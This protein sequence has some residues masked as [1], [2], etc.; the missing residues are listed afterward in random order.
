[1]AVGAAAALGRAALGRAATRNGRLWKLAVILAGG[2][3]TVLMPVLVL[4]AFR[5]VTA[6]VLQHVA[7]APP[8]FLAID[9]YRAAEQCPFARGGDAGNALGTAFLV[10]SA[11]VMTSDGGHQFG[12]YRNPVGDPSHVPADM[13]PAD[14]SEL[15]P[16]GG[17]HDELRLPTSRAVQP[18]DWTSVAPLSGEYGVGFL[19][20]TRSDW[21]NWARDVPAS[22]SRPL[23]PYQPYDAFMVMACHLRAVEHHAGVDAWGAM[24]LWA[25]TQVLSADVNRALSSGLDVRQTIDNIVSDLKQLVSAGVSLGARFANAVASFMGPAAMGTDELAMGQVPPS[26]A[27]LQ[28]IPPNYLVLIRKWAAAYGIDWTV[29]AGLLMVEDSFGQG[30]GRS[31]AGALGPAQFLPS[32]F[33]QYGVDDGSDGKTDAPDIWN[34][35]DAIASAAN[36]LKALGAG[37]TSTLRSA[38]CRYNT[39]GPGSSAYQPCMDGTQL[40]FDYAD[41][42][43][44]YARQYR[45]ALTAVTTGLVTGGS[46]PAAI[47][48]AIDFAMKQLGKPYLYGGTGPDSWDCSGLVQ[49]AYAAAGIQL[50]RTSQ[51]QWNRGPRVGLPHQPGDLVFFV[52]ADGTSTAPGHVGL[53]IDSNHMIVAPSTGLNV[54]IQPI[55]SQ[56]YVGATRPSAPSTTQV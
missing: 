35:A 45:G 7:V 13:R 44:S 34:P 53:A 14:P 17:V 55:Y 21:L 3:V 24:A 25:A 38:L 36:Y 18:Q 11:W 16:G 43:M 28:S 4:M 50:P 6:H 47:Q 54:Q 42:V 56:G 52:G 15:A 8:G 5:S 20:I 41:R 10:G 12:G 29:L 9:A 23:D 22:V 46:N 31:S 26:A 1:M 32:T 30:S 2:G 39:G 37:N 19:L 51:A 40:P 33:R 48:T 49:A 27:A